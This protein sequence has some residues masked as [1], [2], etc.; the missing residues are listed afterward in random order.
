MRVIPV[1]DIA[2]GVAVH[3][4]GGARAAY[5]PVRSVLSPVDGD[6]ARLA[7]AFRDALGLDELYIADLDA[8]TTGAA[9]TGFVRLLSR[10][11]V[12][13]WLDAGVSDAA[14]ARAALAEG[15]GR[16]VI[17]LETL[18]SALAL[19]EIV[20]EI[21]G[22][23][24]AFSVDLRGGIPVMHPE[25]AAS[26][27]PVEPVALAEL[28]ISLGIR[29]LI[30]LDLARVGSEQGVDPVLPTAIRARAPAVE[31][32]AGGGVRDVTD[33]VALGRAGCDAALVGTALHDGRIGARELRQ[34]AA[35]GGRDRGDA[36]A[37]DR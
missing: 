5:A 15:A 34:L 2:G 16:V 23:P 32:V 33:V 9:P 37:R 1:L 21:G 6:I 10:S 19:E 22:E 29:R 20:G 14:R 3:A 18:P 35:R 25:G 8:I 13:V 30:V 7:G 31:L 27:L 4:R 36:P 28:A 12:R 11:G 17:A 24:L 26:G